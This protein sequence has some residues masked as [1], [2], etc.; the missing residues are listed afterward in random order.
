MFTG[1]PSE[2]CDC[3]CITAVLKE[4]IFSFIFLREEIKEEETEIES[5]LRHAVQASEQAAR[6]G[7]PSTRSSTRVAESKATTQPSITVFRRNP[8]PRSV[9]EKDR[10]RRKSRC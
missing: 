9:Q 7:G 10:N 3:Y 6:E 8:L 1:M 4:N 2:D 5:L